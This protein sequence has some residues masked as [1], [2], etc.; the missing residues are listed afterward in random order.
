[1]YDK[2]ELVEGFATLKDALIQYREAVATSSPGCR[3]G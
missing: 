3:R 1:M 2:L